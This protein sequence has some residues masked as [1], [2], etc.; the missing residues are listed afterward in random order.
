MLYQLSRNGRKEGVCALAKVEING[1]AAAAHVC[2]PRARREREHTGRLEDARKGTDAVVLFVIIIL[3]SL[4]H[5][6]SC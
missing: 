2:V 4:K 1:A 3:A 5:G 6:N